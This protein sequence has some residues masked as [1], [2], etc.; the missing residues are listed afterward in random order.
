M[1][2]EMLHKEFI[3]EDDGLKAIEY[4]LKNSEMLTFKTNK[5]NYIGVSGSGC[6]GVLQMKLEAICQR[7]AYYSRAWYSFDEASDLG[8][9]II[10]GEKAH[11]IVMNRLKYDGEYLN[12]NHYIDFIDRY[13]N[14]RK[15]IDCS[16]IEIEKK[17]ILLFNGDQITGLREGIR[18]DVKEYEL[19]ESARF[20]QKN[21]V[22]VFSNYFLYEAYNKNY[23][24]VL[25]GD[26]HDISSKELKGIIGG[27]LIN[28]ILAEKCL[29][30]NGYRS[31]KFN[32]Q[33]EKIAG[34]SKKD[35]SHRERRK[36]EIFSNNAKVVEIVKAN[37]EKILQVDRSGKGFVCPCCNA[38][39]GKNGTGMV[40]ASK[41]STDKDYDKF[42]CFS[43]GKIMK[44]DIISIVMISQNVDFMT[45]L[46]DLARIN[47]VDHF[48]SNTDY[49]KDNELDNL[50]RGLE[51][52]LEK[53]LE[54]ERKRQEQ[55]RKL[56]NTLYHISLNN[57]DMYGYFAKRGFTDE[58]KLKKLGVGSLDYYRF[59][60]EQ[61]ELKSVLIRTGERSAK[62]RAVEDHEKYRYTSIGP[63]GIYGLSELQN[64]DNKCVFVTEGEFDAMS[65]LYHGI[66]AVAISGTSGVDKLAEEVKKLDKPPILISALDNDERGG[67][68]IDKLVK[69]LDGYVELNR[70]FSFPIG[71]KDANEW[72]VKDESAFLSAARSIMRDVVDSVSKTE[73]HSRD[74]EV[75]I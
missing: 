43:C 21:L 75:K 33:A 60:E 10:K 72:L 54:E 74:V 58:D 34:M 37:P 20:T 40:R 50:Y 69:L 6:F 46:K 9:K 23:Q 27:A 16:K 63:A 59:G 66:P 41:H 13:E 12:F 42:S 44:Q 39:T 19:P 57:G 70:D 47:H 35:D 18:A 68:A 8:G 53:N 31:S 17:R 61:V 45:A 30:E 1:K 5:R 14:N 2:Q 25:S 65:F 36:Q 24:T 28:Y 3:S 64:S 29:I 4:I 32:I 26:L 52:K 11:R 48:L 22:D 55:K 7:N 38:G 67:E 73:K 51:S 56:V 15:S 49:R 62:I 71:I